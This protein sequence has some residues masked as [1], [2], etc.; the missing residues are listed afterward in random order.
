M[1]TFHR[2]SNVKL[3]IAERSCK[4][5][6]KLYMAQFSFFKQELK[7]KNDMQLVA[8]L[9]QLLKIFLMF[10][11]C[12]TSLLHNLTTV[13]RPSF[14]SSYKGSTS[15]RAE[16]MVRVVRKEQGGQNKGSSPPSPL[17]HQP[18][19][20]QMHNQQGRLAPIAGGSTPRSPGNSHTG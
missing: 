15:W 20:G 16:G 17:S 10:N 1:S 13:I 18:P 6:P 14:R 7:R 12:R 8:H 5:N 3:S 19:T 11:S 9:L 4:L 2:L